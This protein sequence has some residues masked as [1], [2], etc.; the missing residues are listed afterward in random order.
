MTGT[1]RSADG[2]SAIPALLTVVVLILAVVA[3]GFMGTFSADPVLEPGVA[4]DSQESTPAP[5]PSGT[6]Q[7]LPDGAD[8]VVISGD[9][10]AGVVLLLLTGG[11]ALLVRFLLRSRRRR[12]SGEGL[13]EQTDLQQ[14]G[15]LEL[16]ARELPTWTETSSAALAAD[17]DTSDAVIRC[18]L[19]FERLCAAAGV[20]RRPTQTTSDFASSAAE[21]LDLPEEPLSALNHLYQ[22]ARFGRTGSNTRSPL[23]P[24]DREL[25][26]TSIS[27]LRHALSARGR[28]IG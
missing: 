11:L 17:E 16:V 28:G 9:V 20:G 18:W 8:R 25:A 26:R 5:S 3:A 1:P 24:R 15:T 14:P 22:R 10:L 6:P 19:D 12:M 4:V 21:A 23:C 27:T 2:S 13:L 7:P